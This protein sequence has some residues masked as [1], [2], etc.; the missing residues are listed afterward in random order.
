MRNILL[1]FVL[2]ESN[3]LLKLEKQISKILIPLTSIALVDTP[4]TKLSPLKQ[5]WKE[6]RKERLNHGLQ[7]SLA[8]YVGKKGMVWHLYAIL[9]SGITW[10]TMLNEH[11]LW[12]IISR[13]FGYSHL[14]RKLKKKNW[15]KKMQEYLGRS[16]NLI[17]KSLEGTR[18][19]HLQKNE[20]HYI[21]GFRKW[22]TNSYQK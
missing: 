15:G 16:D 9:V 13:S 21:M 22:V 11:V 8:Q 17:G 18:L 7:N 5:Q 14:D 19:K 10:R 1:E 2:S 20:N 3:L 12:M 4:N 6:E